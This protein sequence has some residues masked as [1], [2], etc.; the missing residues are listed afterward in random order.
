MGWGY[1]LVWP[2]LL[3]DAGLHMGIVDATPVAHD[4][5]KPVTN[6]VYQVAHDQMTKFLPKRPSLTKLEAFC[7]V[8]SF[9]E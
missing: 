9:L 1:D 7:I 3:R 8:R 4:L 5:R 2:V 6:Y